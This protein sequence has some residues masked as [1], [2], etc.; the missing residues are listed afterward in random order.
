MKRKDN[1]FTRE[2]KEQAAIVSCAL[3]V[4]A[5]MVSVAVI[6]RHFVG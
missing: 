5:L 4:I 6:K 2:Q 1:K 3:I